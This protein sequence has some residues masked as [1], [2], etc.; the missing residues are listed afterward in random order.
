MF[1]RNIN[2]TRQIRLKIQVSFSFETSTKL[3]QT[4]QRYNPATQYSLHLYWLQILEQSRNGQRVDLTYVWQLPEEEST[5][6]VKIRQTTIQIVRQERDIHNKQLQESADHAYAVGICCGT[7]CHST[8]HKN[9]LWIQASWIV[10]TDQYK[11]HSLFFYSRDFVGTWNVQHGVRRKYFCLTPKT[12]DLLQS[13]FM[14]I[15]HYQSRSKIIWFSKF[16][17]TILADGRLYKLWNLS[18]R[19][20]KV[21]GKAIPLLALTGPEGS[22]SLYSQILRQLAHEGGK[23]VCPTHWPPLPPGN[24]PGTHLC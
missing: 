23:V 2:P 15:Y 22:R 1:W 8:H 17:W 24:S 3:Y 13:D 20:V 21:K 5:N 7:Y 6:T 12:G 18:W 10:V 16:S 4:T 19:K 14:S 11:I 9:F